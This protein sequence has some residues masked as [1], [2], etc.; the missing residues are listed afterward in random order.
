[1]M[2]EKIYWEIFMDKIFEESESEIRYRKAREHLSKRQR[3]EIIAKITIEEWQKWK[4]EGPL[5]DYT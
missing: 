2:S 5:K 4:K 3:C 1:M